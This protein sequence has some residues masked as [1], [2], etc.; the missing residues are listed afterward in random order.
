MR[1]SAIE[2]Y[3][4]EQ[5]AKVGGRAYKWVS[6]G[7]RGVPDR[8]VI[9]PDG[10]I[11]FVELKAPGGRLRPEQKVQRKKIVDMCHPYVLLQSKADV[12][13]MMTELGF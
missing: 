4:V 9:L 10:F 3:L 1:E 11:V 6:P 13:H 5:V 8:I 2:R 7:N 12:D